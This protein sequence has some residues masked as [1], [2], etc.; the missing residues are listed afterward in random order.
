MVFNS[1][2]YL[3]FLAIVLAI[4]WSLQRVRQGYRWQNRFLLLAS[5]FFYGWWDWLFLSLILL[6]TG[7]D[8]ATARWIETAQSEAR[9]RILISISVIS[10]LSILGIFKYFNFFA[11]SLVQAA[12]VFDAGAFSDAHSATLLSVVLPVGISF[13]TFQT[14]AYTIDVFRR[15]IPAER[16]FLDFALFVTFFPQLVA[17]PIERA[18]D[19]LPQLKRPRSIAWQDIEAGAWF[20]LLGFFLKTYIA[21]SLSPLVDRVF[22]PGRGIY[23]A[24][25]TYAAGFNGAQ[26][27]VACVAFMFQIYGD[28]AGYSIIAL[29]SARLLGVRLTMN[30]ET[31][32]YSLNP[33]ELWRR[34]HATLNRWISDYVYVPLGGSRHGN[35]KKWR[36]L[37]LA[38]FLSGLW[39][40]ASWSF[41]LWGAYLGLWTVLYDAF[42][43]RLPRLPAGAPAFLR[44]GSVV[45]RM[46]GVTLLFSLSAVFFRAYDFG[47]TIAL[48]RSLLTTN[49]D[50]T[51]AINNVKPAGVYALEVLQKV[52][53]LLVLDAMWRRSGDPL[54]IFQRNPWFRG[55]AY[56]SLYSLI[57]IY[58]VF[59]KDVIYFAF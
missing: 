4:Y 11:D 21:D 31:P 6:S 27:L 44:G 13:Y 52:G 41:V 36:N 34:W 2:I 45:M 24:D 26:V 58:G 29:G 17:G 57:V 15:R 48:F 53:L 51:H 43:E 59:G 38:F 37:F 50:W 39:H 55:A 22:L 12:R 8:Y 7:I 19:L 30:F 10:N 3:V 33:A 18:E 20:L 5:Y 16:D 28:F 9:R 46:A 47:H 49:W 42:R 25:P 56:C 35:W 54:W 1:F 40:G 14:M 32:Q 23:L